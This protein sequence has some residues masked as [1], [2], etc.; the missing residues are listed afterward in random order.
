MDRRTEPLE[1]RWNAMK[2]LLRD[3]SG[4]LPMS[5]VLNQALLPLCSGNFGQVASPQ[6][7]EEMLATI[8][9]NWKAV[10]D[11]EELGTRYMWGHEHKL[12][13]QSRFILRK[14]S[15]IM[16]IAKCIRHMRYAA[17]K[18]YENSRL[19][20]GIVFI[21]FPQ[22]L[23][24]Q[25]RPPGRTSLIT[26]H[27]IIRFNSPR[28]IEDLSD[29]DFLELL[30]LSDG[31]R[32]LLWANP[33]AE[34]KGVLVLDEGCASSFGDINLLLDRHGTITLSNRFSMPFA[35]DGFEWDRIWERD[36]VRLLGDWLPSANPG[37]ATKEPKYKQPYPY[38]GLGL[39]L[40]SLSEFRLSSLVAIT[41]K[42]DFER[43]KKNGQIVP[44]KP[45]QQ[46]FE[47]HQIFDRP[48]GSIPLLRRDGAH[49]FDESLA[50]LGLCQRIVVDAQTTGHP[51]SGTN[52][53]AYLSSV[54]SKG[55]VAKVS[56]DGPIKL[57]HGGQRLSKK[58][59]V[60]GM[61]L[62]P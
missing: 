35:F 8:S 61:E 23:E 54:L 30:Q 57:F 53:A 26:L 28:R 25:I 41:T 16:A 12:D 17:N 11:P 51:G 21:D 13:E 1:D 47:F 10:L 22:V 46:D 43:L 44:M 52:A 62:A 56:S 15:F 50:P 19:F 31:K 3:D 39:A 36:A 45:A 4:K 5:E 37:F 32:S 6:V 60:G 20:S 58:D 14:E 7:V 18:T 2:M 29:D 33:Q 34:I 24:S 55:L 27:D 42:S 48:I 9:T 40:T 38:S 49:I 59:F